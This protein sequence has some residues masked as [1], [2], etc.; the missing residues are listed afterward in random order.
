MGGLEGRSGK[1]EER[2][3]LE[4]ECRRKEAGECGWDDVDISQGEMSQGWE[5]REELA[6]RVEVEARG[7]LIE[8]SE[9]GEGRERRR[10]GQ[11]K[12]DLAT[13]EG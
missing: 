8:A 11:D 9:D 3:G 2:E 1:V 5:V 6:D 10:E 12:V 7:M 13:A 4:R